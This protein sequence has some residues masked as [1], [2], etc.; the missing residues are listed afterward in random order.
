MQL[1]VNGNSH[2]HQGDG[3]LPSLLEELQAADDRVAIMLNDNIISRR[4]R[5]SVVLC[6]GDRV[7]VLMFAGG[8]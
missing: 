1:I 5:E 8:G 6:A 7:E 4:N 2:E 3:S